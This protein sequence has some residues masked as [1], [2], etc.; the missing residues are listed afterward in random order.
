MKLAADRLS[1]ARWLGRACLLVC[2][3]S[4][5]A[6]P[7]ERRLASRWDL[8]ELGRD[9][10]HALAAFQEADAVAA[11]G[12]LEEAAALFE[13]VGALAPKSP[14]PP[15]RLC[16]IF[17][18][19]GR[20]EEA[21]RACKKTLEFGDAPEDYRAMVGAMMAGASPP[22]V[23]EVVMALL[24]A[25]G[26]Q[27]RVS[28]DPS[29]YAALFDI[30]RRT[31][32]I[33]MMKARL[34]EL[35]RIAPDHYDTGRAR[36]IVAA[37]TGPTAF[38]VIGWGALVA[39]AVAS[40]ARAGSLL[41][42]RTRVRATTASSLAA[43]GLVALLAGAARAETPPDPTSGLSRWKLSDSDPEGSLPAREE[44]RQDPVQFGYLVFDLAEKAEQATRRKD[45]GLAIKQYQALIKLAPDRSIGHGKICEVHELAGERALALE[46]CRRAL[47]L[48]GVRGEDY[49]RF[50][51][52]VLGNPAGPTEAEVE[53]LGVILAHLDSQPENAA[54]AAGIE[55]ALASAK[56][57]TS[58][59]R[60]ALDRARAAGVA[61]A[62]LQ[63]MEKATRQAERTQSL[64]YLM[65]VVLV[66]AAASLL[67]VRR[68]E[69]QAAL[70]RKSPS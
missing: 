67:W 28:N 56:K 70:A 10:P 63:Q 68:R 64:S 24:M 45:W 32:D 26:L 43:L 53:E 20:R 18:E 37:A 7:P 54:A 14:A 55:W 12:R 36:R 57:D 39:L 4:A 30:A 3:S 60:R 52:L 25:S 16:E 50:V 34:Q 51:R 46:A 40:L 17:T 5:L 48:D 29:G 58:R 49:A 11:A 9:F 41:K 44:L 23:E 19:L 1:P 59:A 61:G 27:Q 66:L 38:T 42:A 21:L 22:H 6:A 65:A 47:R 62:E 15:R 33:Q 35:E 69:L 2:A 8:K 31:G 13:E